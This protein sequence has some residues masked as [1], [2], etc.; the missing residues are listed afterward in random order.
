VSAWLLTFAAL[1]A[2][3]MAVVV[4]WPLRQAGRTGFIAA[5]LVIG[6][7]GAA[8][9]QIAGTPPTGCGPHTQDPGRATPCVAETQPEA[10]TPTDLQQG[11]EDLQKALAQD[12]QR[13]DGWALLGRSQQALGQL[14]EATDAYERAIALAP[15][16]APLLVEAAQARA[17]AHPARQFDDTAL[18]WLRHAQQVEP[19]NERAAWL[20]GVALRQRGQNAEAAAT[21]EALLPRLEAGAAAAL[22]EQIAI[23]RGQPAAAPAQTD[24]PA[25]GLRVTVSVDPTLAQSL[26]ADATV[27]VIARQAGGPPMPVAVEKHALADLP[28]Q[29]TLDDGDSPMPTAKLSSLD[30]VEVF[31]RVSVSGQASRQDGDIDSPVVRVRVPHSEVVKLVVGSR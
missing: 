2:A 30:E 18:N 3:A 21:W 10:T 12:P 15:D 28:L 5:C 4:L 26:P 31:A 29:V 25:G 20:I 11:I 13:A 22:R 7:A 24:A 8:L 23:A 1:S 19:T 16:E 14:T 17:Q 27:F 9:Y 6:I